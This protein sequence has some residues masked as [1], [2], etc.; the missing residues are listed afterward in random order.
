MLYDVRAVRVTA[1]AEIQAYL[2][3]LGD[4]YESSE[5]DVSDFQADSDEPASAILFRIE[6]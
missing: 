1:V 5:A 6:A 4:K 2:D 3:G